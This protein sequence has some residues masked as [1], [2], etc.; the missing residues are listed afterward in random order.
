M[1]IDWQRVLHFIYDNRLSISATIGAFV[2]AAV[3]TSPELIPRT[4]QD[5]WTWARDGAHQLLNARKN[6]L[7]K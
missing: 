5:L 3:F 1:H 6:P 7:G 2:S 4:P